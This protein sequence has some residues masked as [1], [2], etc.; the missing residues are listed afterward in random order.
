MRSL[1]IF[2]ILPYL[3][4]GPFIITMSGSP[5]A[6][7]ELPENFETKVNAQLTIYLSQED[8]KGKVKESK[9][10]KMK[11]AVFTFLDNNYVEFLQM[12]SECLTTRTHAYVCIGLCI[13]EQ[14]PGQLQLD[15]VTYPVCICIPPCILNSPPNMGTHDHVISIQSPCIAILYT[16]LKYYNMTFSLSQS[17]SQSDLVLL[18]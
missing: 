7:E 12:L 9:S 18:C 3:H 16:T 11:E 1:N 17:L 6:L 2:L 13:L 15:P 10:Q 8:S 14:Y 4:L 5:E